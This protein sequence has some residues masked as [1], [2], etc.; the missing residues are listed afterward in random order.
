MLLQVEGG[1]GER[2]VI[3]RATERAQCYGGGGRQMPHQTAG[4]RP[5]AACCGL[6]LSSI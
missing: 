1:A 2:A 6:Q 3:A 5:S 4:A